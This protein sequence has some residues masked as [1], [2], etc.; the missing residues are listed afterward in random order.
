ME[1]AKRYAIV[2]GVA[3]YD[4]TEIGRLQ[5]TKN[6]ALRVANLLIRHGGFEARQVYL[7]A[8]GL[9]EDEQTMVQ[10]IRPTRGELL[11]RVNY[12]AGKAGHQ[13]LILLF[14]A[15][16]GAEVSKSPYLL[17]LQR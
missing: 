6:D 7:L 1:I 13:D 14:F 9:E 17:I 8:N 4:E 3:D 16:H 12:V 11:R 5:Y 15:G 2:I 10:V